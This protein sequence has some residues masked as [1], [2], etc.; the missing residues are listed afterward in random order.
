MEDNLTKEIES[1]TDDNMIVTRN[2]V[3]NAI[4]L[5][6]IF[7]TQDERNDMVMKVFRLV[8]KKYIGPNNPIFE[9]KKKSIIG[10]IAKS[11]A[12]SVK[13]GKSNIS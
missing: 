9:E 4:T 8:E 12:V 6:K 13:T 10:T 1:S 2:A 3:D 11:Y 7:C 5:C